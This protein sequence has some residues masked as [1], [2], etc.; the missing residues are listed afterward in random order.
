MSLM[1]VS[2]LSNQ[3]LEEQSVNARKQVD[4]FLY[5]ISDIKSE[6][7]RM[8]QGNFCR[9]TSHKERYIGVYR[10]LADDMDSIRVNMSKALLQITRTANQIYDSSE[11]LSKTAEE[12]SQGGNVQNLAVDK[13]MIAIESIVSETEDIAVIAKQNA[14]AAD[15][16]QTASEELYRHANKLQDM[17]S[18]FVL[19]K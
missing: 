12:V 9:D 16:T 18:L 15:E 6:M 17:A 11:D 4:A 19:E 10:Q 5:I 7:G 8:A 3:I 13:L 14:G 2:R 1:V